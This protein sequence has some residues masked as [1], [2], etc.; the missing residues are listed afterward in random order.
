MENRFSD[1]PEVNGSNFLDFAL[2]G[3][4]IT[5][6]TLSPFV[7]LHACFLKLHQTRAF[8]EITTPD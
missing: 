8:W 3:Q 1:G 5:Q 6:G 2:F 4:V 7:V